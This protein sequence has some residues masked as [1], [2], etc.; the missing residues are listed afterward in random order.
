MAVKRL[1]SLGRLGSRFK[2]PARKMT[3]VVAKRKIRCVISVSD[4][5][6]IPQGKCIEKTRIGVLSNSVSATIK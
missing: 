5:R 4:W 2:S 1:L 3:S 6:E